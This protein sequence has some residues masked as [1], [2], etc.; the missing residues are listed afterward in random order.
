[1][2]LFL[3]LLLLPT[4]IF[5]SKILSYNVYDRTDRVDIMFAFDT[6]YEG[7]LRQTQQ[8]NTIIIKLDN[9][10]IE[11]PKVKNVASPFLSKL[12]IT[13]IGNQTQ[14]ITTVSPSV[15]MQASKTSDAFG[16]RLRF[17]KPAT[18]T[19]A[20]QAKTASPVAALPTKPEGQYDQSYMI[21]I[22]IL[23]VAIVVLL[24]LKSRIGKAPSSASAAKPWLFSKKSGG[25]KDDVNIR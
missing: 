8:N 24:W 12:T 14:I 18:A 19:T 3:P 25:L 1:M 4:L 9:A 13:P 15:K 16:L 22:L 10:T 11:S 6:P 7:T 23:L 20:N 17:Y 21:V 5:A 2:R